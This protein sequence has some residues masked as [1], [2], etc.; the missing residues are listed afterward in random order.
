M[1]DYNVWLKHG[2]THNVYF[3]IESDDSIEDAEI[4]FSGTYDE[5]KQ[6]IKDN[7]V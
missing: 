2:S 6:Y 7:P 4:V 5:C 1:D 3:I